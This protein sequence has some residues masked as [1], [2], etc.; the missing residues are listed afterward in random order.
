MASTQAVINKY[1]MIAAMLWYQNQGTNIIVF[2]FKVFF[3]F[4]Q[5]S[6]L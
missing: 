5:P 3:F 6:Y 2:V 4:T 1:V